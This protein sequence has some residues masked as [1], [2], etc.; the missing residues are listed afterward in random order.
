MVKHEKAML[1]MAELE[2]GES[3]WKRVRKWVGTGGVRCRFTAYLVMKIGET[4]KITE[5]LRFPPIRPVLRKIQQQ[6][7]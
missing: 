7:E 3:Y 6:N 1:K 5:I 4:R 2:G